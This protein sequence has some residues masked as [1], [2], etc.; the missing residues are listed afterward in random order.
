MIIVDAEVYSELDLTK[1]G[2][3]R[4]AMHPST[5]AIIWAYKVNDEPV[6][7]YLPNSGEPIPE[8]LLSEEPIYAFNAAFDYAIWH[9]ASNLPNR[10]THLWHDVMTLAN[11]YS[12]YGS[13]DDIAMQLKLPVRK[14]PAGK[15]L[16]EEIC[17][18]SA[19]PPTKAEWLA[20]CEYAK[21]DAE[22]TYAVLQALP[23]SM[24]NE[25]EQEMWQ[26][27]LAT[28][29]YG[30]PVDV[31]TAKYIQA[32]LSEYKIMLNANLPL[33][34]GG[35]ITKATQTKRIKKFLEEQGVF[36]PNVTAETVSSTLDSNLP[37]PETA[38]QVLELRQE[39]NMSSTAKYD[40]IV[41]GEYDGRVYF[42]LQ[43]LGSAT[44]RWAGR[45]FQI[46]NLPRA[47]FE[48]PEEIIRKF[49]KHE[50][51]ENPV[52]AAKALIRPMVYAPPNMRLMVADYSSIENFLALWTSGELEALE[53][54]KGGADQY[55]D[56]AQEIF[57]CAEINS[58]QRF[59]G[60]V[61]VLGRQY[62]MGVDRGVEQ[63][64]SMGE[65]IDRD[66]MQHAIKAFDRKYPRLKAMR[67]TLSKLAVLAIMHPGN[68][69]VDCKCGFQVLI[70]RNKNSW[71]VLYLPNGAKL[72][73]YEPCIQ[74][75]MYG[76]QAAHTAFARNNKPYIYSLSPGRLIENVMQA[77]ARFVLVA[78]IQAVQATLPYH[79]F[80]G[81]VHDEA[82]SEVHVKHATQKKL[83]EFCTVL[84][85]PEPWSKDIGIRAKGFITKRYRKD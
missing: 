38:R 1:V 54:L 79:R 33:L 27:T 23:T 2:T 46:L 80:I 50:Y 55:I 41:N 58:F 44:T 63:A 31:L 28:N 77:L 83:N 34:T 18:P 78:G 71:L 4:Y 39:L 61:C 85:T 84:C 75:T 29:L 43:S 67:Y 9:L 66:L 6:Q 32:H 20:F 74:N 25:L 69:F 16:M 42:T 70:D 7:I 35:A 81:L 53:R 37:M 73:Y 76:L 57:A 26:F 68:K 30:L 64:A 8:A 19:I 36:L 60:K 56:M 47:S 49:R 62:G 13:L 17:S 40:L 12:F 22:V 52:Y 5:R 82:I 72:F 51:I 21:R 11:R 59:V 45:N 3:M 48:E 14:D 65:T 24:L 10:P 15:A